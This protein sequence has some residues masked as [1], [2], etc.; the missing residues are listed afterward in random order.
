MRTTLQTLNR[1]ALLHMRNAAERKAEAASKVSSGVEVEAP[2]DS[3]VDAAGIVRARS[4]L[5]RVAQLT[6]NLETTRAELRAVDGALFQTHNALTRALELATQA[7]NSTQTA[8]SRELIGEEVQGIERHLATIANS[9]HAG[10]YLFAGGADSEAPFVREGG[11]GRFVYQGDSLSRE[12][13]F[14]DG[15][16]DAVSLPGDVVFALPDEAVGS[17]RAPG[18]AGPAP[19][20]PVGVGLVFSGDV[21]GVISVDLPG[22]FVAPAPPSGA[23]AGDTVSVQLVSDDGAIDETIQA[24]LAGGE[25]AAGI[26]ALLNAEVAANAK[27]AGKLTFSDEG[28]ALKL[29]QSDTVGQG[30][31]FSSSSTGGAT[32]GLESGG[33]VGGH[34]AEEIAA[35]L[36]AEI[37]LDPTL[38][39]AQITVT[40]VDGELVV[41]G[42]ADFEL[43]V[44]DFDRG[45]GF[46]SGLAGEHRVGGAN[47]A[48][49]FGALDGLIQA[50]KTDD[51][52]AIAEAVEE[53]KRA[54]DHVSGSQ[55]FYGSTLRRIELTLE[56]LDRLEVV[57]QERLSS[58]RDADIIAAIADLEAATAAERFALQVAARRQPTLLDVLG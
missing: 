58:H 38:S 27:L 41:D 13:T 37:A 52:P 36:N 16:A 50:L 25:G 33:A 17:G 44:V 42:A 57:N 10:R 31:V 9:I 47:S 24:T 45:T 49:A 28:G 32:T 43:N 12:I 19:S 54:V 21:D 2:S 46:Q 29:V 4:E 40:A 30:F 11:D 34:S 51:G 15:R 7:A 1:E 39:G 53:L 55:A 26:A 6:A 48:D 22:F 18:V 5:N 3:P 35:A 20:P 56:N 23:L 14:S 8:Q